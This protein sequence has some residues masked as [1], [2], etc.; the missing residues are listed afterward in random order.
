MRPQ[1]GGCAFAQQKEAI[2]VVRA[3]QE[4]PLMREVSETQREMAKDTGAQKFMGALREFAGKLG[5]ETEARTLR[6]KTDTLVAGPWA[7]GAVMGGMSFIAVKND[8]MVSVDFGP[9][10]YEKAKALVAKAMERL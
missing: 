2:G 5:V 6:L 10:V 1:G 4:E 8:V 9:V 3:A 7:E